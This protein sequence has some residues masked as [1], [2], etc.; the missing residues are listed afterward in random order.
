MLRRF[1]CAAIACFVVSPLAAQEWA[2]KMFQTSEHDFGTVARGAKAEFDFVLSNLYIADVHIS[3]V[4]TSCTCTS[5]EAVRPSLKTYENGIIRATFNTAAFLGSHGATITVSF[6]KPYP[7]E[8]QLHVRGYIRSDVV[9]EPGS[10]QFGQLEQ[11]AGGQQK[12]VLNYSGQN[13]WAITAVKSSNPH[14]SASFAPVNRYDG[15]TSYELSVRLDAKTPVGYLKDH[16][17]L[18]TNEESPTEIPLEVE[19]RVVAA[20][21]VSPATLFM[22]V[23]E[24]RKEVTKAMV[25]KANKPFRITSIT[26]DDKS[27]KFGKERDTSPKTVHV[28]PV[29]FLAGKETGKVARTIRITTDL[30]QTMP[31]LSAYAVVST[32]K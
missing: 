18:V 30:G 14:V 31:T 4:R 11:G 1:A 12:V 7:A 24:P 27:F 28:I 8:A 15:Q 25:I 5:V 23:V 16:L 2:Q 22:G 26:S 19:G 32:P 29:T 20:V 21:T 10:V 17:A 6:D 3:G 13:G 9:F